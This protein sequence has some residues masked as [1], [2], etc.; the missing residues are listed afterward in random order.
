MKTAWNRCAVATWIVAGLGWGAGAGI[1]APLEVA[2]AVFHADQPYPEYASLWREG[3]KWI[4]DQG[5]RVRYA[6][7]ASLGGY[8]QLYLRNNSADPVLLQDVLVDGVSLAA[9]IAPAPDAAGSG[10]KYAS[11][12]AFSRLSEREIGKLRDAGEPVWWK[13]DPNP[14]EPGS[15]AEVTIRLRHHPERDVIEVTAAGEGARV[16]GVV[17]VSHS[18]PRI[19]GISF[20]AS[21]DEAYLYVRYPDAGGSK[22]NRVVV[23]GNDVTDSACF[24]FDPGMRTA[25]ATVRLPGATREP[26]FHCFQ[27]SCEDGSHATASIRAWTPTFRYGMWGVPR[28]GDSPEERA[29]RY[30]ERLSAHNINTIMSHYGGDV[31]EYVSRGEGKALLGKLGMRIMDHGYG[32]FDDPVYYY[33]PDEPDAHDFA[34]KEIEAPEDRLGSLARWVLD[35]GRDLRTKDPDTLLLCNIDN[36]YKPEQWYM[37]AQLPDI[38]CADPYYPEQLRSIYQFDPGSLSAYIK[39]TYVYAVGH[40][41]HTAGAPKPMHLILHTCR[42]DM[43]EFPFRAPTPEEKRVEVFYAVAGGAKGISF[44]WYTPWGEYYGCGARTPDMESL[45]TEIG[46]LGAEVG[47]AGPLITRSHPVDL[48]TQAPRALWIRWLLAGADTLVGIVVNDNIACD[49]AGF[50]SQPIENARMSVRP[51]AWLAVQ[52]VFEIASPGTRDIGFQAETGAL[53][54]DLGTV[55]LTRMVVATADKRLRAE[56]QREYES[57]YAENVE[58]LLAVK[59]QIQRKVDR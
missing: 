21:M 17:R 31:R 32:S 15:L 55:E 12:L 37:Y 18:R 13:V 39:P 57:R 27:V 14:V 59:E 51:P 54:V 4:D 49:R 24:V 48:S 34:S 20:S 9:G 10:E 2:D 58:R 50:T 1:G 35:V 33:L 5:Q 43:D 25:L 38:I 36:T 42:F 44:W 28:E 45:L 22:P 47:T 23:D 41:Y 11:G 53:K 8:L 40:I 46:L 16:S 26:A 52:D 29:R 3:W 6:D 19:A 30:L 7:Y 56:L